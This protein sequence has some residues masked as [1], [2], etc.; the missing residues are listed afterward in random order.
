MRARGVTTRRRNTRVISTGHGTPAWRLG[1]SNPSPANSSVPR[2]SQ[3]EGGWGGKGV[4]RVSME[5]AE[6]ANATKRSFWATTQSNGSGQLKVAL[7]AW[8]ANWVGTD[9]PVGIH[10]TWAARI[11]L[12]KKTS[13]K[14]AGKCIGLFAAVVF[15]C[16]TKGCGCHFRCVVPGCRV[17]IST[18]APGQVSFQEI[19]GGV[20]GYFQ[21]NTLGIAGE[22]PG[23]I[24]AAQRPRLP[25][26]TPHYKLGLAGRGGELAGLRERTTK[27]RY[28]RVRAP[29]SP[30]RR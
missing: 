5:R 30:C 27:W 23:E 22:I 7:G 16:L 3:R 11:I 10:A 14:E 19:P 9:C 20:G 15:G 24:P 28:A 6:S 21:N 8:R 26:P 29:M 12:F 2:G 17:V 4:T 25:H 13:F 18:S 1:P